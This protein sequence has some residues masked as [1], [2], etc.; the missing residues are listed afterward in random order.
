MTPPVD[1]MAPHQ[2]YSSRTMIDKNPGC[3]DREKP[4]IS[5]CLKRM[6]LHPFFIRLSPSCLS[7]P[8]CPPLPPPD[9]FR[10]LCCA[11]L[12]L[13]A[14]GRFLDEGVLEDYDRKTTA[15][16]AVA[17]LRAG[18][19]ATALEILR[20]VVK[21]GPAA[22]AVAANAAAA[23]ANVSG[24]EERDD[25]EEEEDWDMIA[26][27]EEEEEIVDAEGQVLP[28]LLGYYLDR[29]GKERSQEAAAGVRHCRGGGVCV[30]LLRLEW[31]GRRSVV[32]MYICILYA[33]SNVYQ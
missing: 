25:D 33:R 30:F 13:D 26:A 4:F 8:P 7:Q 24:D 21:P 2:C 32:G 9:A 18:D 14:C 15:G 28:E 16:L 12:L 31:K 10:T 27:E 11:W 17:C 29:V 20:S 5:I 3:Q 23:A 19:E 22:A 1:Q 6:L